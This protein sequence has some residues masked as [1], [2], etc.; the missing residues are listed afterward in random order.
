ML[1]LLPFIKTV[2]QKWYQ[3]PREIAEISGTTKDWKTQGPFH[4]PTKF[5]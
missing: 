2:S 3:I 5:V 1:Q 4:I